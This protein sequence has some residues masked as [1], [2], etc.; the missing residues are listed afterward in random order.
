MLCCVVC[1]VLCCVVL[2]YIILHYWAFCNSFYLTLN[3]DSS[4]YRLSMLCV[5][6][7]ACARGK[8]FLVLLQTHPNKCFLGGG[9]INLSSS[10]FYCKFMNLYIDQLTIF[11][12]FKF[13]LMVLFSVN[14][15]QANNA[16]LKHCLFLPDNRHIEFESSMCYIDS[17]LLNSCVRIQPSNREVGYSVKKYHAMSSHQVESIREGTYANP[18]MMLEDDVI[19]PTSKS[20]RQAATSHNHSC[21]N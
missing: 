12:D 7:C 21:H 4:L 17:R 19:E 1:V 3:M 14:N 9:G 11:N 16:I 13:H 18:P 15:Q 2:Y 8:Y 10:V 5:R 20:S 6:V